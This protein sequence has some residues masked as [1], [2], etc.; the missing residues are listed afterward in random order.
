MSTFQ[1]IRRWLV[2]PP[3]IVAI[4]I[5]LVG[6]VFSAYA[7][8]QL[9]SD[10]TTGT[11]AFSP[12]AV[13]SDL[14]ATVS[15]LEDYIQYLE[16]GVLYR[17]LAERKAYKSVKLVPYIKRYR[18]YYNPYS[19]ELEIYVPAKYQNQPLAKLYDALRNFKA[20]SD[21]ASIQRNAAENYLNLVIG[22][23]A[24]WLFFLLLPKFIELGK[25]IPISRI[26]AVCIESWRKLMVLGSVVWAV[27]ATWEMSPNRSG[28][29]AIIVG[30]FLIALASISCF[31][32]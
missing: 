11:R 7:A 32:A 8:N 26:R 16:T 25:R 15:G 21:I 2:M 22:G 9:K 3:A 30:P 13:S 29:Y 28:E 5:G 31:R 27:L 23:G 18:M 4:V 24:V 20:R 10:E 19:E 12:S 14:W 17:G 1:K 6:Y